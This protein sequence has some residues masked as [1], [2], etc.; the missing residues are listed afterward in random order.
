MAVAAHILLNIEVYEVPINSQH[1]PNICLLAIRN[2]GASTRV[3]GKQFRALQQRLASSGCSGDRNSVCQKASEESDDEVF[4]R[5][6]R[7]QYTFIRQPTRLEQVRQSGRMLPE[8]LHGYNFGARLRALEETV[9][10]PIRLLTHPRHQNVDKI[11]H[12]LLP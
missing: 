7:Q 3:M 4:F 5:S 6:A 8:R 9:R 2:N 12:T 10:N 1:A 11:V